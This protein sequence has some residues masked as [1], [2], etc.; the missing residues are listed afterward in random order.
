[1]DNTGM[2]TDRLRFLLKLAIGEHNTLLVI[3][4]TFELLTRKDR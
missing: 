1:M 2:S 4:Y 3:E